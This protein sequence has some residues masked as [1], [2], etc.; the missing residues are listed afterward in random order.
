MLEKLDLNIV[1]EKKE[2]K[3]RKNKLEQRLTAL[4][5]D[6]MAQGIPVVI[7]IA[8]WEA[9][10]KG[11]ILNEM[12]LPFDPRGYSVYYADAP[13]CEEI[14]YPFLWRFWTR[15][16]A[17]GRIAVF[18]QSW[19]RTV[20][21]EKV[22]GERT[23]NGVSMAYDAITAFERQLADD[24]AL[25]LKFF[26]HIS[27]KEQRKRLDALAAKSATA[28]RVSKKD[29][30]QNKN[31]RKYVAAYEE[32]LSRTHAA[33]APWIPVEAHDR[34]HSILKV[35]EHIAEAIERAVSVSKGNKPAAE[36][37]S[38]KPADPTVRVLR[39]VNMAAKLERRQYD[40]LLDE[41]QA[42][43]HELHQ[44]LRSKG[45]GVAIVFEGWDAAGKGG[46]IRRLAR[47]MDPRGYEVIPISA[48]SETEKAHHY[49]WRFWRTLPPT[50]FVK[51]FDRSWYGR[52]LVE[53][54]E[55]FCDEPAWR[56]AYSEINEMER[57][58]TDE[59]MELIKFWLNISDAEQLARFKARQANSLKA[60]KITDEDWRNRKQWKNYE[61]A[62]NEM[63]FRTSTPAAPWTIVP[64]NCKL[65]SRIMVLD[66][67]IKALER[68]LKK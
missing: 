40:K 34:R 22:N 41:K 64:A 13:N 37:S 39:K 8:G 7:V 23:R 9:S 28:W 60:W 26:L 48:P 53:R 54:I 6:V 52:V 3:A 63:L 62:I 35:M 45:P 51:I 33:Y 32:M 25:V 50:G 5:R 11:T 66:T 19:Y 12:I 18:A 55:G 43:L 24:G 17:R 31:Y 61:R 65:Y 42:R 59:G 68:R 30:R 20:T 1:A 16:P 47:A 36:R 49:L 67:V 38:T 15:T 21:D 10:G 27:R 14:R 46:A 29:R 57:H 44:E 56:R 2:Y 58:I 4:Q